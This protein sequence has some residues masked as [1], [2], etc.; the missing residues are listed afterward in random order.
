MNLKLY[1]TFHSPELYD[2]YNLKTDEIRICFPSYNLD[3]N[4]ININYANPV[5]CEFVTMYYVW[6]NRLYSQ[7]VGF[8]HY[9]RK[10]DK[11]I[12]ELNHNQ[13]YVMNLYRNKQKVKYDFYSD[14]TTHIYNTCLL[15]LKYKYKNIDLY[16]TM[17]NTTNFIPY[18]CFI[19]SYSNFEKMCECIFPILFD[20]DIIYDGYLIF[21]NYLKIFNYDSYQAR[22]LAFLGER[23]ISC[24]IL[25]YFE[26]DNILVLNE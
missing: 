25:T 14:H 22:Q 9:R 4:G 2:K 11:Q 19:M 17:N 1:C 3:I 8:E 20:L 16:N 24:Y 23:L 26:L 5:L 7:F 21:D 15:L 12:P 6:K 10:F 13:C 18:S